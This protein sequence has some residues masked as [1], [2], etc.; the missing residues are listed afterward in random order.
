MS[1][2]FLNEYTCSSVDAHVGGSRVEHKTLNSVV[3]PPQSSSVLVQA[4]A[5]SSP[6][7]FPTLGIASSFSTPFAMSITVI[8]STISFVPEM[9][10]RNF[11]F[12][13]R[14][15]GNWIEKLSLPALDMRVAIRV[16]LIVLRERIVL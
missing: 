2:R 10:G 5:C 4:A 15:R 1:N 9:Y 8:R 7:P 16:F 6:V 14:R 13:L 12:Q 11:P 3:N